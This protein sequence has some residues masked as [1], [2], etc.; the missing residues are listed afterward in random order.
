MKLVLPYCCWFLAAIVVCMSGLQSASGNSVFS[1]QIH[2]KIYLNS[3]TVSVLRWQS[4]YQYRGLLQRN[5]DFCC[6]LDRSS[7]WRPSVGL[8]CTV[9]ITWPQTL[10]ISLSC[11]TWH[12]DG[13]CQGVDLES[14]FQQTSWIW[15]YFKTRLQE[16]SEQPGRTFCKTGVLCLVGL[17]SLA[18]GTHR[19]MRASPVKSC[20]DGCQI[21]T[22]DGWG[23]ARGSGFVQPW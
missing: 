2:L 7:I 22:Q 13:S 12:N 11:S 17:G 20:K 9:L 21:E 14:D 8:F 10:V 3:Q 5:S 19:Q 18:R 1:W 23:V 15:F 16:Y 6:V 4:V